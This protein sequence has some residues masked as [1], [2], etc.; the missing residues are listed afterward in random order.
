MNAQHVSPNPYDNMQ[1]LQEYF[2]SLSPA[3]QVA[4]FMSVAEKFHRAN[5]S[6]QELKQTVERINRQ[7]D[8]AL[9]RISTL[10]KEL[11][12]QGCTEAA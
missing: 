11:Q 10:Q 7:Y 8:R 3:Q 5:A 2:E 12:E 4:L 1:Y 6:N 9:T